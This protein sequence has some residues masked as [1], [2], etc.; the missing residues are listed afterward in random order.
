MKI[1]ATHGSVVV[2]FHEYRREGTIII[3]DRFMPQPV[4]CTVVSDSA[5]E[6]GGLLAI[7]S[8]CDG[9]YFKV[10]EVEYCVLKRKSIL[11]LY[12]ETKDGKVA[13][14]RP[15]TRGVITDEP[16]RVDKVGSFFMP[17]NDDRFPP[18]AKVLAV[19]PGRWD[20]AEGDTIHFDRSKAMVIAIDGKRALF[21]FESSIYAMEKQEAA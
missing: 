1:K 11:L 18:H 4:E 15:A 13:T 9:T 5:G 12:T 10:D 3:P 2:K 6:W 19:G 17:E 16:G 7:A 14:L 20:F 8:L 21:M